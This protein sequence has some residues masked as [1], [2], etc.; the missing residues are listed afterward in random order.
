MPK[1]GVEGKAARNRAPQ[2]DFA[3]ALGIGKSAKQQK[4]AEA[5]A[6]RTG[7]RSE[8]AVAAA[9]GETRDGEPSIRG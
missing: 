6:E 9:G 3:E 8:T 2:G 1:T 4:S 7:G 5:K